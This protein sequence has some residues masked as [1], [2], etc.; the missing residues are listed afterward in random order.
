MR[1]LNGARAEVSALLPAR[2]PLADVFA[3]ASRTIIGPGVEV[4]V[5]TESVGGSLGGSPGW[6]APARTVGRLPTALL[7]VDCRTALLAPAGARSGPV[8]ID[9]PE[10]VHVCV[11]AFAGV[12][13]AAQPPEPVVPGIISHGVLRALGRGLTDETAARELRMSARSYRRRV[14]ELMAEIGA[15]SRFQAGALAAQ[16]G[17][18]DREAG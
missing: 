7:V 8:V 4:R 5:V 12:W 2:H 10:L 14:S 3:E 17:W 6:P 9:R 11:M 15:A 16:R 18:L 1:L 13:R